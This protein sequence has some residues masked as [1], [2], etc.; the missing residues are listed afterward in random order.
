MAAFLSACSGPGGSSANSTK[1]GNFST[2]LDALAAESGETDALPESDG[3]VSL[4]DVLAEADRAHQ[5]DEG[6]RYEEILPPPAQPPPE[7]APKVV[8][9]PAPVPAPAPVVRLSR[10]EQVAKLAAELR[11]TLVNGAPDS[12]EFRNALTLAALSLATPN[13]AADDA[14]L[15]EAE[16]RVVSTVRELLASLSSDQGESDAAAK[17]FLRAAESLGGGQPSMRIARVEL[18]STVTGFGRYEPMGTTFA[19][20]RPNRVIV[21]TELDK[22]SHRPSHDGD[23][24]RTLGAT[25]AEELW[26]VEVSQELRMTHDA[27]GSMQWR[28]PEEKI[29][30]VARNRRR[31]FYLVQSVTLPQTLSVGNYALKVIVRDKLS[32]ATDER[33]VPVRIVADPALVRAR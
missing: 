4:S 17:A 20:G 32:G 30:E 6:R 10:S 15:T 13:A 11:A 24:G 16:R 5:R 27:D 18:C 14:S 29:I 33:I 23:P 31:D 9:A 7:P 21:Y 22:V 12:E 1:N 2:G 26:A 8:V 3:G 19:A 25:S 28:T